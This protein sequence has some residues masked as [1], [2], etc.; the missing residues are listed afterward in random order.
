MSKR[1]TRSKSKFHG[2]LDK[3]PYIWLFQKFDTGLEF[4]DQLL[5]YSL[6]TQ[7]GVKIA[8]SETSNMQFVV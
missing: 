3:E 5:Q 2:P 6:N 4:K 8:K 7:Y 1:K